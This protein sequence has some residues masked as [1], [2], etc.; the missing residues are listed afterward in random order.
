MAVINYDRFVEEGLGECLHLKF[1]QIETA[2]QEN[3]LQLLKISDNFM[4][5]QCILGEDC[6]FEP[7]EFDSMF[8]FTTSV[9][10]DIQNKLFI[11]RHKNKL[12]E[13]ESSNKDSDK[14]VEG[15]NRNDSSAAYKSSSPEK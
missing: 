14:V 1:M 10:E 15:L 9:I 3:Q 13:R 4:K 12:S 8:E 11:H 7:I 5:L 6:D 2:F